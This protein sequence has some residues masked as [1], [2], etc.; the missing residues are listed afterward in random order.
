MDAN[1]VWLTFDP[2]PIFTK[3]RKEIQAG[4]EIWKETMQKKK[5]KYARVPV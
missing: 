2:V 5:K 4:Q 1:M 3:V